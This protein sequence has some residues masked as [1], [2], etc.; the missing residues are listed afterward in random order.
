MKKYTYLKLYSNAKIISF[1]HKF[2]SVK[3]AMALVIK[4]YFVAAVNFIGFGQEA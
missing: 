2:R 4:Q 1:F 3:L